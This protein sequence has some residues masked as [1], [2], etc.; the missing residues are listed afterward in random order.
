[1]G[2]AVLGVLLAPIIAAVFLIDRFL[3]VFIVH[4]KAPTAIEYFMD[5]K[6]IGE[7]LLRVVS[8]AIVV[9]LIVLFW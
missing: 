5:M 7:S 8:F 2:R 4:L 6:Y 9:L 1:M 3:M